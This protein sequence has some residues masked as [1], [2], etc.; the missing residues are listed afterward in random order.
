MRTEANPDPAPDPAPDDAPDD[1]TVSGMNG[2][3]ARCT[4]TAKT[5]GARCRSP[6]VTGRSTCRMHGGT[7]PRGPAHPSYKHGRFSKLLGDRD[8]YAAALGDPA[9][10]GFRE[11]LALLD[12]RTFDLLEAAYGPDGSGGLSVRRL[13]ET[14]ENVR[15]AW[16]EGDDDALALALN[17]HAEAMDGAGAADDAWAELASVLDTR[18]KAA[19]AMQLAEVRSERAISAERFNHLLGYVLDSVARRVGGLREGGDII[20]ALS[21]DLDPILGGLKKGEA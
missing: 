3:P 21:R 13:R 5:T 4:A 18:R 10:D 2:R 14:W 17:D 1:D 8:D 9:I 6:A 20:R 19:A 15:A 16:A 11:T 12:V 7:T